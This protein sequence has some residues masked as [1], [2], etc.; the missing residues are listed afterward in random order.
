[1]PAVE[2]IRIEGLRELQRGFKGVSKDASKGLRVELRKVGEG[3][4]SL[5]ESKASSEIT[6]IGPKWG[7]MRLGVTTSY[8]YIA[9]RS[10]RGTG[11]PRPNLAGLLMSRAMIPAA[12]ESQEATVLAVEGMLDRISVAN[13]FSHI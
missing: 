6:R 10:R 3:V 8:V 1:M 13:G 5:A 11:S 4:R 2:G 7:R 12:E 9:P